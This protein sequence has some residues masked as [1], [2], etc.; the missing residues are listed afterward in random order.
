M[1]NVTIPVASPILSQE[2]LE[3]IDGLRGVAALYILVYHLALLPQPNLTVPLW[4]SR[5]VLT[6]GTGVTLFFLMS[7]F[8]LCLS[9]QKRRQ[10]SQLTMNFY[11]RRFF[12]IAP[13][14]YF[15]TK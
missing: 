15:W 12:R 2:R 14:F 8:C 1:C 7:P 6:G 4:A 13:L 3:A 10:E 9:K 11:L 5:F